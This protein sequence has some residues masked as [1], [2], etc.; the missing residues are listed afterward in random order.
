MTPG[1]ISSPSTFNEL[2]LASLMRYIW[3]AT[4]LEDKLNTPVSV[5]GR[6]VWYFILSVFLH[7]KKVTEII[8]T[9]DH[10]LIEE[11]WINRQKMDFDLIMD[12]TIYISAS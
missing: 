10:S 1:V 9:R 6:F 2:T 3:M 5:K 4:L 7:P 11:M 12:S 8:K